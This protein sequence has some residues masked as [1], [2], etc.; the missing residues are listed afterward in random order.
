[1]YEPVLNATYLA[2][3]T[4][5]GFA[6]N[7]CMSR[8]PEHKGVVER[9][10]GYTK[11]NALDGRVFESLDDGN[12]LLRHWNKRWARNRIHGT[13]K[14]QVLKLFTEIGQPLLRLLGDKP[15]EYF[16]TGR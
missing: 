1:M 15:F 6:A 10:I 16:Q 14:C 4:H 8:T 9:D 13:T 5:W 7:P 12:A 11:H 3:A 2:F